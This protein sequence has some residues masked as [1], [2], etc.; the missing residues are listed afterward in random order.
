MAHTSSSPDQH[1]PS[2]MTTDH[3]RLQT[4]RALRH[5][6]FRLLWIGLVVSG[7]GTW[8]QII[9]Q[10]LLVLKLT[11]S[12]FALGL[13][14]LAQAASFFL[15]ALIGGSLADR[16]D[17]RRLLLFT[18]SL[19]MLLAFLLGILTITNVI[20]V[21]MIVILAFCS[22]TIL[23][24]DQPTRSS[25]VPVLVPR[26]DLMNAVS[27]QS[28]VFNGSAVLGPSLAGLTIAR[29][30]FAGNFFLNGIS[31]LGVL[32]ALFV[33]RVP[34]TDGQ[35]IEKRIPT[36]SAIGEALK[37]IGKDSALPWVLSGYAAMLFFG[38]S[39]SLI[40]PI[41]A[42]QVLHLSPLQLGLLFSAAGL[43][44]L[45]GA[46]TIAS[47]GD[48]QH[49]GLLL[50]FSLLIW[51]GGLFLLAL[52]RNF[53][54]SLLALLIVG[55]AQNGIG[56]TT[57]TLMQ[58]RVPPQMRGRAMSLNTLCIMGLRPL[59]DFPAG[60]LIPF[61]GAPVLVFGSAS[62]VGLYSLYLLLARPSIR[63]L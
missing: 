53:E 54:V 40:L 44:T 18:Q 50:L 36:F 57:I 2:P 12:A 42:T 41:F 9:A 31:F 15:F 38:P 39:T 26:E 33:L 11:G 49:K 22:G 60:A 29:I 61:L 14:S 20:Q 13:V 28:I 4:F 8:M 45:L 46:L 34:K 62:I 24:F 3:G 19:S 27:L 1:N 21:W 30:G 37:T 32:G 56:A 5:R 16:F 35:N 43:G 59:G 58:T 25:L 7:I 6:D 52:S 63:S 55:I 47:L 10:S 17:K 23:S 48:F 51:T